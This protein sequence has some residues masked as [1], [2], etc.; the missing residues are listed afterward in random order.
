MQAIIAARDA[1]DAAVK[2]A[3]ARA[4]KAISSARERCRSVEAEARTAIAKAEA[5]ASAA[6]DTAARMS[7]KQAEM[8]GNL[9]RLTKALAEAQEA[10]RHETKSLLM[11]I[12]ALKRS[13]SESLENSQKASEQ[14]IRELQES[15]A[16]I[17]EQVRPCASRATILLLSSTRQQSNN[18]GHVTLTTTQAH[19]QQKKADASLH[20][21]ES[22]IADLKADH[23]AAVAEAQQKYSAE[24]DAANKLR[25]EEVSQARTAAETAANRAASEI[26]SLNSRIADLEAELQALQESSSQ[27]IESLNNRVTELRDETEDAVETAVE[28]AE[29]LSEIR[30]KDLRQEVAQLKQEREEDEMRFRETVENLVQELEDAQ[31]GA[32][33]KGRAALM[34]QAAEK[35]RID[36]ET[37]IEQLESNLRAE[38]DSRRTKIDA[39]RRELNGHIQDLTAQRDKLE[40]ELRKSSEAVEHALDEK[41]EI[42]R[43]HTRLQKRHNELV[44]EARRKAIADMRNQLQDD[45]AREKRARAREQEEAETA[46]QRKDDRIHNLE[47]LLRPLQRDHSLLQETLSKQRVVMTKQAKKLK[48]QKAELDALKRDV[49]RR[50]RTN[51]GGS[52]SPARASAA[53]IENS[54]TWGKVFPGNVSLDESTDQPSA[55]TVDDDS[56]DWKKVDLP[57]TIAIPD[58]PPSSPR[59]TQLPAVSSAA[60]KESETRLDDTPVGT[61]RRAS[62]TSADTR[63]FL[64]NLQLTA[65]AE[66]P[67]SQG[68]LMRGRVRF[69]RVGRTKYSGRANSMVFKALKTPDP[70]KA[71]VFRVYNR[72]EAVT[73]YGFSGSAPEG[74]TGKQAASDKIEFIVAVEPSGSDCDFKVRTTKGV[75]FEMQAEN[76][77]ERDGWVKALNQSL[78][79]VE[80]FHNVI[81]RSEAASSSKK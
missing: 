35:A 73:M 36:A 44:K 28:D 32:G 15:L 38:K 12:A 64:R 7:K 62:S 18:S 81:E 40:K 70:W 6:A 74:Q 52:S 72:E 8:E 27:K 2:E 63:D 68:V 23:E 67:S 79:M 50:A 24:L 43:E 42:Q 45:I 1:K 20:A 51:T 56:E 16:T 29:I 37:K 13:T 69:R 34:I 5:S 78:L 26:S 59:P 60:S 46:R 30:M 19:S 71:C 49:L 14:Q 17:K 80:K 33:A 31:S 65:N 66:A 21:A 39:V 22:A 53:G 48:E 55:S 76:A 41:D 25:V 54:P 75:D 4:D 58:S 11:E 10:K 9:D 77:E 61:P 3:N 47:V 57:K